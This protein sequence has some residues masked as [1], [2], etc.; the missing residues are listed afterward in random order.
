MKASKS[1]KLIEVEDDA[2]YSEKQS[3]L[4]RDNEIMNKTEEIF[5]RTS[6]G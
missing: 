4:Y 6:Q 1:K 3:Q 2:T 5:R